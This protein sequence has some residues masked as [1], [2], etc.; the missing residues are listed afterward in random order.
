[1]KGTCDQH[2]ITVDIEFD[3]QVKVVFVTFLNCTVDISLSKVY[4]LEG[5]HYIHDTKF[6]EL[7][8]TSWGRRVENICINFFG[9]ILHI[10]VFFH[11]FIYS[12]VC[13]FI[14][15]SLSVMPDSLQ[16]HRLFSPWDSPGQNA[17]VGSLSLLQGTF[18]TQGS[19]PGLPH[20]R[21]ILYQ[22]SQKGSPLYQYELMNTYF[23]LWVVMQY[24]LLVCL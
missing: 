21:R 5:S 19:N 16:P 24:S 14:S 12:S 11:L 7:C 4:F 3:Y 23:L 2:D 20:C 1:M 13:F 17:G 6:G 15:E 8:L 22:L 9:I 18:P 10:C